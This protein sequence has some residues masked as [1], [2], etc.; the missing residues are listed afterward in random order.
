MVILLIL[1]TGYCY[2]KYL[3]T[4]NWLEEQKSFYLTRSFYW[5]HYP[6][7]FEDERIH[8]KH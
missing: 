8:F 5:T 6:E 2:M 3:Q 1:I 4:K 7:K